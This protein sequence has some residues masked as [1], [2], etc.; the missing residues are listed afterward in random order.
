VLQRHPF[1]THHQDQWTSA[2][3]DDCSQAQCCQW[4]QTAASSHCPSIAEFQAGH[5]AGVIANG[6]PVQS[7][8][9]VSISEGCLAGVGGR[10][11][12]IL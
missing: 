7:K 10:V 11:D 3:P 5:S 12:R 2:E 4:D 1:E 6:M 9:A 8:G